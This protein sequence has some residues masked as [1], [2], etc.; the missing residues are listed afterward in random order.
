MAKMVT[1][2]SRHRFIEKV[3]SPLHRGTPSTQASQGTACIAR[4]NVQFAI[5]EFTVIR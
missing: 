1:A 5:I 4:G 3:R 2:L